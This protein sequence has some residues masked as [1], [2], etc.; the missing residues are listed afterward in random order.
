LAGGSVGEGGGGRA[1]ESAAVVD[2]R[3]AVWLNGSG[4][5]GAVGGC[6]AEL[7]GE[8]REEEDDRE[9]EDATRSNEED[10]DWEDMKTPQGHT[11]H[12]V[13]EGH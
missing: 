4:A 1:E 7:K 8:G 3:M 5:V 10:D 13:I 11:L 6:R 2:G 12:R 9:D